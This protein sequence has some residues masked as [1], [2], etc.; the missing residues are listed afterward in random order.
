MKQTVIAAFVMIGLVF[1][2]QVFA[3][4]ASDVLKP[5]LGK[6]LSTC[7]VCGMDVFE[8][9][10]SRVDIADGK[11]IVYACALGCASALLE[12][13]KDASIEVYDYDT[14]TMTSAMEAYFVFG[15]RVVPAR[16]MLP[17]LSF[18]TK[19]GAERFQKLHG[20]TTFKGRSAFDLAAKIRAERMSEKKETTKVHE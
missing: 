14:G 16:A 5:D 4:R 3:Q 9:M 6:K 12:H 15:S 1:S 10:L 2:T 17:V 11:G 18:A 20:G 7:P 19:D 8:G 13:Q